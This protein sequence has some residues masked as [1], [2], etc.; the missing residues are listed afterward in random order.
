[1]KEEEE[2]GGQVLSEPVR[3]QP[4]LTY[5]VLRVLASKIGGG[6]EKLA[7]FLGMPYDNINK[8]K[9]DVR[10]TEERT[11]RM[12]MQFRE[13]T[14]DLR[15][16]EQLRGALRTSGRV[17]LAEFLDNELR[18]EGHHHHHPELTPYDCKYTISHFF[19]FFLMRSL[20]QHISI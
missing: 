20:N 16:I 3:V 11:F 15:Q 7:T 19:S 2:D 13:V 10:L 9:E 18:S 8:I 4:R 5:R 14:E 17:D 12:L 1:M 6:W